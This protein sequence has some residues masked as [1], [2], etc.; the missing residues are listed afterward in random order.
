MRNLSNNLQYVTN[1]KQCYLHNNK[2]EDILK[3][4][5]I[6]L[7]LGGVLYYRDMK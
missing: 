1:Y 3:L 6:A 7:A 5:N 2:S 4:V